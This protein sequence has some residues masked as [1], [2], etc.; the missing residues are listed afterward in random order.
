MIKNRFSIYTILIFTI[1]FQLFA[2]D[3]LK[4]NNVKRTEFIKG[5]DLSMLLM[6]LRKM[7]EFIKRMGL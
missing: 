6:R 2:Q 7:E 5:V 1:A 4:E 3:D